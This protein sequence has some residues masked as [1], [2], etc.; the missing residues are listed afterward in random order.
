M[1]GPPGP[2]GPPGQPGRDG[3]PG[4][5]LDSDGVKYVTVPGPPGPPVNL[6]I[7]NFKTVNC[8]LFRGLLDRLDCRLWGRRVSLDS[9]LLFSEILLLVLRILDDRVCILLKR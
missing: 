1:I 4:R 6:R 7:V 5:S 3:V 2:P 8:G 9:R